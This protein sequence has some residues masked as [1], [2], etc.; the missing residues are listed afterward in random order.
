MIGAKGQNHRSYHE[1]QVEGYNRRIPPEHAAPCAPPL[2]TEFSIS[3]K[4]LTIVKSIWYK[5]TSLCNFGGLKICF[6]EK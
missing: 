3:H 6:L 1:S 5:K 2:L 4:L